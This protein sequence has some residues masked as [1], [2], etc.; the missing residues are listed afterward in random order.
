MQQWIGRWT[1]GR[2]AYMER[3]CS[4]LPVGCFEG[5]YFIDIRPTKSRLVTCFLNH[6]QVSALHAVGHWLLPVSYQLLLLDWLVWT[7]QAHHP[8]Q[9]HDW[10]TSGWQMS[11]H[12]SPH[13][14]SATINPAP[15]SRFPLFAS[16]VCRFPILNTQYLP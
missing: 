13:F 15:F 2:T 5:L 6:G 11:K 16:F 8:P 3:E 9:Y 10:A 7:I 1:D 4:I 14:S 12:S